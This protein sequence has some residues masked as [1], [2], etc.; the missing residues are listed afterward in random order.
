VAP[1]PL[2]LGGGRDLVRFGEAG[3]KWRILGILVGAQKTTVQIGIWRTKAKPM[4]F[5]WE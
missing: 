3:C 5:R 2:E 4:S 1:K